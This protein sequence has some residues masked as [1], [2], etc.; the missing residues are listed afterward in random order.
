MFTKQLLPLTFVYANVKLFFQALVFSLDIHFL[1]VKP[2]LQALVFFFD[3]CFL[4]VKPFLQA[5]VLP[6]CVMLNLFSKDWCNL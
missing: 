1:N 2:L 5:L 4:N 6:V 3:I